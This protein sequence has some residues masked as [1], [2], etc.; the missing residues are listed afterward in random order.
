MKLN[1]LFK[2]LIDIAFF[3]LVPVVIFFPGTILYMVLFPA[4]EIITIDVPFEN[5]GLTLA[6]ILFLSF[7][8]IEIL[9]FFIGF[10]NLRKLA[11]LTLKK[12]NFFS[13]SAVIKLKRIGQFFS[14][15]GGS[16]L[17]ILFAFQFYIRTTTITFGLSP[18]ELLLFLFII[19]IFFLMLSDAFKRALNYKSENDLTI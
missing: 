10:I 19:G 14:I 7:V 13:P 4:Q 17:V 8:F 2:T 3:F 1:F 6:S 9:L 5:D 12:K 11:A 18:F 16:S 15:C